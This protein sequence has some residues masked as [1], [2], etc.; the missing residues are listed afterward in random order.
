MSGPDAPSV[1]EPPQEKRTGL[2]PQAVEPLPDD[3]QRHDTG[4][5]FDH[6]RDLQTPAKELAERHESRKTSRMAI[7]PM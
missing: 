6:F 2:R 1:E 3:A 7:V 5:F 4:A